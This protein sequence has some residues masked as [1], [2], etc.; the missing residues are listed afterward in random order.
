[1][2]GFIAKK[3]K[4]GI[5]EYRAETLLTDYRKIWIFGLIDE[6]CAFEIINQL[7]VMDLE[8]NKEITILI[9]SPGGSVNAGM[10]IYDVMRLLRSP[11]RTVAV[12]TVASMASILFSAGD[13]GNREI[14]SSSRIM[15][16]D[17][18][19]FSDKEV[20]TATQVIELGK[21]IQSIKN[22]INSILAENCGKSLKEVNMDTLVDK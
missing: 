1:M 10:E 5:R 18:R 4:D 9:S 13:K 11:I 16:H 15:I 8:S 17:P 14:L 19:I 6:K 3:S 21:N 12:G 2:N 7:L 22:K 20:M